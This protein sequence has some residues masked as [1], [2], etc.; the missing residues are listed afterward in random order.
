MK[1]LYMHTLEG[2][3]ASY[4]ERCGLCFE[5]KRIQLAASLRQIRSEQAAD[6]R[7]RIEEGFLN[8]EAKYGYA[9]VA[10]PEQGAK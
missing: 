7:R 3:P 2:R 6:K 1:L 9:T 5:T 8:E 4:S 10:R